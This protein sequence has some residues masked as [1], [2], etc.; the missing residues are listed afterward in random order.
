MAGGGDT[1]ASD[2][3]DVNAETFNKAEALVMV[4]IL[5]SLAFHSFFDYLE[6]V[7]PP[8][9]LLSRENLNFSF[10]LQKLHHH[11]HLSMMLSHLYK[12]LIFTKFTFSK[13]LNFL[14]RSELLVLGFTSFVLFVFESTD[15]HL[16]TNDKHI[17]EIVHM[18][19][20]VFVLLWLRF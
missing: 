4:T 13:I 11:K 20:R 5:I 8:P 18:T 12:G 3:H 10:F 6:E 9:F 15:V 19:V 16:D 14:F 2:G 7:P 17:F 1:A